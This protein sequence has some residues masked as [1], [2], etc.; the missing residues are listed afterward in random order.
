MIAFVPTLVALVAEAAWIAVLAD[1]LQ[2]FVLRVPVLGLP[3][4]L[5]AAVL[6]LA[7]TRTLGPRLG[8]RW[9]WTAVW[10]AAGAGAVGWLAAPEVRAILAER[11]IDGAGPALAA[12]PGGWVAAVAFVRGVAHA[13]LPADPRTIDTV[14]GL[15]VPGLA[16]TAIVGGMVADPWRG[17]FLAEAQAGVMVFL[18]A[19]I[20][21]L[22]L[23]RLTLVGAGSGA[24]WRR[25]P[26]WLALLL[27]LLA[28]LA[29]AAVTTSLFAG[30][31]IVMIL[32]AAL[33]TLLLLGFVVGFDRRSGRILAIS[34]LIAAG[35]G[36]VLRAVGARPAVTPE[37]PGPSIPS[38]PDASSGTPIAIVLLVVFLLVAGVAVLVLARQWLRRPRA[39]EDELGEVRW[40]D[41]GELSERP[42]SGRRGR[43]FHLG[44]PTPT[45]AVTAYRALL[46]ELSSRA[47]VWREP[48]ETPAEHA[49]RL[50]RAG[51]GALS[52]DLLAADY[53][54]ARFGG[55][56]LS[57]AEDRRG[58]RRWSLLRRRLTE[59]PVAALAAKGAGRVEEERPGDAEAPGR[60]PGARTRFRIG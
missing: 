31:A 45:D 17:R 49:A 7:A 36:T 16:L 20:L 8:E 52:L 51:I 38:Q 58:V 23:S 47:G 12:N 42:A 43:A 50:R 34:V 48:G 3:A 19:G 26:A 59:A 27:V 46:E 9:P 41:R 2:A 33:P 28:A 5:L 22:A 54:L 4:F 14:L 55:V 44:R 11:G 56:R 21:A 35:I 24:D 10:L 15:G 30:P 53:G 37:V 57:A 32:G 60:G 13:R 40:I 6:G 1:L 39:P 25:N 29:A 18:V